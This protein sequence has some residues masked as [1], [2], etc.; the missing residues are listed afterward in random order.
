MKFLIINGPNLNTLGIREPDVYGKKTYESLCEFIKDE[1]RNLDVE[2]VIFQS[3]SEGAIIDE[4]Q[5]TFSKFDGIIIN[6]GAYTHYSYAIHDALKAIGVDSVEVHLSNI[7]RRE[8]FRQKSVTA[9]ACIGQISGMGFYGYKLSM[10]Y[11]KY[12]RPLKG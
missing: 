3:N 7:H 5:K 9:P 12:G 8:E 11:L 4:I 6:P 2:V 10:E 1:A